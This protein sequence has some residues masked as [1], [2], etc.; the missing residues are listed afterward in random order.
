M[1]V[2]LHPWSTDQT[3]SL[4]QTCCLPKE[5]ELSSNSHRSTIEACLQQ[6]VAPG[7]APGPRPTQRKA[8]EM[9][10]V[11]SPETLPKS[12]NLGKVPKRGAV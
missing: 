2:K 12:W 5:R 11:A 1:E 3:V 10:E 4:E 9:N 8:Y 7:W 6:H